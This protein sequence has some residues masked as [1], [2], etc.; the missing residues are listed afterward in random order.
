MAAP[1]SKTGIRGNVGRQDGAAGKATFTTT[2][3][4]IGP[5]RVL[6]AGLAGIR[7]TVTRSASKALSG[8]PDG[9]RLLLQGYADA[10]A[11][12]RTARQRVSFRVDV[13]PDGE[14]FITPCEEA[15]AGSEPEFEQDATPEPGLQAAL[16]AARGRGRLRAAEILSGKDMLNADGFA[17]LLGTTRVTVNSKRQA[18]QILGLDGAK[19]GLRFPVWQLDADGKPYA[20]LALLHDRLGGPWPVYRFLVQPHGELDG[21]I[22]REAL[23]GGRAALALAAAESMG[24]DF[25]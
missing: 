9:L 13:D 12:S 3:L 8:S 18:G 22:G 19:R 25:R 1:N 11:K 20:E 14:T 5:A 10:I 7:L 24:R 21:L 4:Y 16:A 17:K 23:E 15:V 6:P 2:T